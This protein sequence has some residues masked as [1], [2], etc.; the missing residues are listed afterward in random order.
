[1]NHLRQRLTDEPVREGPP[2]RGFAGQR[3]EREWEQAVRRLVVATG[4]R[5]VEQGWSHVQVAQ[6]LNLPPRTLRSWQLGFAQDQLAARALGRPILGASRSQRNEVFRVIDEL[7]PGIGLATLRNIFTDLARAEL[8]YLLS[9]YRRIWRRLHRQSIHVLHWTKPGSVWAIDFHGPCPAIDGL[10]RYVLA[11]RDLASGYQL[12][13]RPVRRCTAQNARQ[14]IESLCVIHGAPL[15]LKADNGSPFIDADFRRLVSAFGVEML[16]SPPRM[17]RYNGAIEAGIGSLISRT[18][19]HAARHGQPG[20][21]TWTDLEAALAEANAT[22]RPFG[23]RGPTPEQ[24][25]NGRA[26]LMGNERWLFQ[27]AVVAHRQ[28]VRDAQGRPLEV[29]QDAV[30]QRATDRQLIRQVLVELGYLHLA[31]RRIP[32]PIPKRKTADIM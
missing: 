16:F 20:Y 29:L 6:C 3:T 18:E 17:P 10:F 7:G 11:V 26:A 21:W 1:V 30:V 2:R 27:S 13:W 31:R 9:R 22:A 4:A 32:L 14:A 23:E 25:W 8:D 15:V 19:Q 12:L 5:L 28:E 24:I